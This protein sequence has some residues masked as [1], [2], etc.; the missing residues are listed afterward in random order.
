VEESSQTASPFGEHQLAAIVF[1]DVVEYSAR[2][3]RDEEGTLTAVEADFKRLRQLC[4]RYRGTVHNTM[5][6]GMLMSFP[7]ATQAVVFAL[8]VQQEFAA[9]SRANPDALRHRI[10][11]HIG[12]VMQSAEGVAGDGVN[13]AARI[14]PL[15]TPG[16]ACLSETV[17]RAV[18]SQLRLKVE[19]MGTPALKNIV[20]PVPVC[21]L[22]I[23]ESRL[24]MRT[25]IATPS[26]RW[27]TA[28]AVVLLLV[29]AIG[30]WRWSKR[31][32]SAKTPGNATASPA[33]AAT[34]ASAKSIA[35]LPFVDLSPTRD[36]EFLSDGIADELMTTLS[37]L[38]DVR[39][40][41][42]SSSFAYK[43]RNLSATEI[44]RELKVAKLL[45][46]TVRKVGS[47]VR[48]S[49]RLTNTADGFQLWSE[50][51]DREIKDVLALQVEIARN[52]AQRLQVMLNDNTRENLE[53]LATSSV[54]AYNSYQKGRQILNRRGTDISEA[55]RFFSGAIAADPYYAA[56]FSGVA[57]C[58]SLRAFNGGA[59]ATD[60]MPRALTAAERA[61]ELDPELAEA[62]AT[63]G[64]IRLFYEWDTRG[65]EEMF[66][67]ALQHS[68]DQTGALMWSGVAR[69]NRGDL[70]GAMASLT[71][72]TE[73]E[74]LSAMA[75]L[76]HGWV[77]LLARKPAEAKPWLEKARELDPN[78]SM[79]YMLLGQLTEA[80][81]DLPGS[82]AQY[83]AG[84]QHSPTSTLLLAHTVRTKALLGRIDEAYAG[85]RELMNRS[86]RGYVR[87]YLF[88][89]AHSGFGEAGVTATLDALQR[90]VNERDPGIATLKYVAVF[91]PVRGQA[92][93]Q[94]MEKRINAKLWNARGG[95]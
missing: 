70:N 86:E 6:D 87:A 12:E 75:N 23:E 52:I 59:A 93:Y 68:P 14:L 9:R 27:G 26:F 45:D 15:A 13:I 62:Y 66:D 82:L 44:G 18:K 76:V 29:A 41:A 67:R 89:V 92:R 20:E 51:Y 84:L 61:S 17:H 46:G 8:R 83:E 69:F 35:V 39:V 24:P 22:D 38:P 49:V 50:T 30:G 88:A 55:L 2:M 7:S 31:T 47:Q 19:S 21:R 78:Y 32:P 81:G 65:A 1:T 25:R 73:A 58:H 54:E 11:I 85:L 16:G 77:L 56:A 37:R 10:G 94:E 34:A 3:A 95:R 57:E 71:Q 72:A 64:F 91:D 36:Q 53:R 42:R 80:E 90:A 33:A 74:P 28:A 5:G 4:A 48:V 40:A 43:G 79:G 60:A 63:I